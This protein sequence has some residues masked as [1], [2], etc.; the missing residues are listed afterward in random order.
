MPTP[1]PTVFKFSVI[2]KPGTAMS[3][4]IK[5][6]TDARDVFAKLSERDVESALT[7]PR[8]TYTP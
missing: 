5:A 4:I 1:K 6:Q 3:E 2:V 7:L 8:G